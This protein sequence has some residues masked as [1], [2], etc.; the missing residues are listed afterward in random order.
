MPTCRQRYTMNTASL[1]NSCS[2]FV[3]AWGRLVSVELLLPSYTARQ[4]WVKCYVVSHLFCICFMWSLVILYS[5]YVYL[6]MAC[7]LTLHV[8]QGMLLSNCPRPG[9]V[10]A[11]MDCTVLSS[12][13]DLFGTFVLLLL[14]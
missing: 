4:M 3:H 13:C 2:R 12:D 10:A 5:L 7:K 6:D 11:Y 14:S 1:H 8:T 9:P